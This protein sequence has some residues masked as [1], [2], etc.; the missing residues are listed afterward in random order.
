ML[1]DVTYMNAMSDDSPKPTKAWDLPD[2]AALADFCS[3]EL[4]ADPQAFALEKICQNSLGFYLVRACAG[5]CGGGGGDACMVMDVFLYLH[6]YMGR[7]IATAITPHHHKQFCR[8]CKEAGG[9]A[10]AAKARFLE[11]VVRYKVSWR[12]VVS[13]C[14]PSPS[15]GAIPVD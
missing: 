4:T 7:R 12:A 2:E 5:V 1:E 6:S 15:I 13:L 11:D 14:A 10:D 3:R 9:E 8:F